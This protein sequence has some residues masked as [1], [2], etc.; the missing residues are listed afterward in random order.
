MWQ[1]GRGGGVEIIQIHPT[2]IK[3]FYFHT[4]Q[5]H[6]PPPWQWPKS[7]KSIIHANYFIA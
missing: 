6:I 3:Q 1:L 7:H 4:A 2:E 5:K